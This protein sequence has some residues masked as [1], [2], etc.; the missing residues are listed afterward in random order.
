MTESLTCNDVVERGIVERY[1]AGRLDLPEA[2]AFEAHYLA[3]PRCQE[4]LRVAAAVRHNLPL[5]TNVQWLRRRWSRP[6]LVGVGLAAAAGFA[7]LFLLP[8]DRV[9]PQLERL[10]A[11][12]EP[13]VYLGVPVRGEQTSADSLFAAAMSSYLARRYDEAARGLAV[14][15]A[16]GVDS[17]PAL[18][19]RASGLLMINRSRES[20]ETFQRVT[21]LGD[22]P[23]LVEARLYR[24]KALLRLGRAGEAITELR[25]AA[26]GLDDLGRWAQ[27]LADSVEALV[28]R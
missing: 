10:G 11:V 16:A 15:L 22:T 25:F 9:N 4:D 21:G 1:L 14:A 28:Q 27:A 19:F 24:A 2:E 12:L 17:A 5:V 8:G 23:Y 3:C 18:F 7:A 13:P 20:A 26:A 6:L